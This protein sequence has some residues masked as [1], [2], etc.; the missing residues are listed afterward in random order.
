MS[1]M[2]LGSGV[3]RMRPLDGDGNPCAEW[4]TFPATGLSMVSDDPPPAEPWR[5]EPPPISFTIRINRRMRRLWFRD[6]FGYTPTQIR[7]IDRRRRNKTH[8]VQRR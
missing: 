3:V 4:V 7:R 6:V 1:G 8:R 5:W 2:V